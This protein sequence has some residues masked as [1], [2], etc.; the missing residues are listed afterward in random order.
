MRLTPLVTKPGGTLGTPST[1]RAR[2]RAFAGEVVVVTVRIVAA[3]RQLC[4]SSA[5]NRTGAAATT[6]S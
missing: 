6:S 1:A 2:V 3:F 4:T 5:T